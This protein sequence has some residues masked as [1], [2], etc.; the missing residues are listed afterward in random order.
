[1]LMQVVSIQLS[2]T[3]SVDRWLSCTVEYAKRGSKVSFILFSTSVE[4]SFKRQVL[5]LVIGIFF[6]FLKLPLIRRLKGDQI[7]EL[8]LS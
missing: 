5:I 6:L 4:K 7:A 2:I 1:M 3:P 8:L